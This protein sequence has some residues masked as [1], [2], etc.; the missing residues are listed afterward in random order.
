LNS[1]RLVAF[2]T[3]DRKRQ[4][5]GVDTVLFQAMI[6]P[7]RSLSARGLRAVIGLILGC[8][9]LILLRV[10]LI[11]AWPVMGFGVVEIG[12]A[13]TLLW[14]NARHSRASELLLLTEDVLSVTRTDAAGRQTKLRLPVAWLSVLVAETPGQV[15]RLLLTAHGIREE[16]GCVLGETERR[17][18]AA[19]LRDALWRM[20]NPLFDN[21]QLRETM[22]P[23]GPSP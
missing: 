17:D 8:T 7:H 15:P 10:W 19:A 22:P 13:M 18:L 23:R 4:D 3:S 12:L 5:A 9:A 2:A 14:R 6:V 1:P 16:I 21:P 11:R 20:R